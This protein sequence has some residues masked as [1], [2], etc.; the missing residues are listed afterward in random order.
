[1]DDER[2]PEITATLTGKQA[3]RLIYPRAIPT[4]FS[5]RTDTLTSRRSGESQSPSGTSPI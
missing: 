5:I 2:D 4:P 3:R 1:M